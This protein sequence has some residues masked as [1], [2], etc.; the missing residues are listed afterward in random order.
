MGRALASRL[1]EF[2]VRYG[3]DFSVSRSCGV[4]KPAGPS[5]LALILI[6]ARLSS[7]I[8]SLQKG[9]FAGYASRNNKSRLFLKF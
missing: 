4:S 2:S 3:S 6:I 5:Q 7:P 8:E 1:P 9:N